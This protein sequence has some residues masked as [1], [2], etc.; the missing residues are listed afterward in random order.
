MAQRPSRYPVLKVR[1]FRAYRT[2]V[3]GSRFRDWAFRGQANARWELVSALSRY[4]TYAGLNPAAWPVQEARILRIFQRK[5]HLFLSHIPG[6]QDHFQWLA[7]M[8]HHGAPTRLLDVTWSPYVALF[9]ALDSGAETAAVWTF[10][11]A[12]LYK[13]VHLLRNGQ[14]V[15]RG[16]ASTWDETSYPKYFLAGQTPFT[17]LGEPRI[18]N[19]RLIAQSGSFMIPGVLDQPVEQIL[20]NYRDS[21]SLLAKIELD[22]SAMRAES[23]RAL[24]GMNITNATLF[25]GLDGLARSMAYELEYHWAYDPV[26]LRP[27]RGYPPPQQLWFWNAGLEP[28]PHDHEEE[29]PPITSQRTRGVGGARKGGRSR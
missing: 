29:K 14:R 2:L 3:D 18:M 5:A 20:G 28:D 16:T 8:Q 7:L 23:M 24:Y 21:R 15:D 6:E 11:P 10:N 22:T 9:F 1:S 27:N 4:L 25:P 26:T 17:I 19:Q 12:P 13:R